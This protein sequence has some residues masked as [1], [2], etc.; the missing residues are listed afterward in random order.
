MYRVTGPVVP[1][2]LGSFP[3]EKE[4]HRRESIEVNLTFEDKSPIAQSEE[5][6]LHVLFLKPNFL[7]KYEQSCIGILFIAEL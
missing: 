1:L 6:S 3:S 4:E 7:L 2:K 5:S